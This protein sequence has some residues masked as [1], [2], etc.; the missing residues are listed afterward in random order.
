MC[1][2]PIPSRPEITYA[3]RGTPSLQ[4]KSYIN[5]VGF[6]YARAEKPLM[7]GETLH[8]PCPYRCQCGKTPHV[9]RG[10]PSDAVPAGPGSAHRA[11]ALCGHVFSIWDLFRCILFPLIYVL[12]IPKSRYLLKSEVLWCAVVLGTVTKINAFVVV[13]CLLCQVLCQVASLFAKPPSQNVLI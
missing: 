9:V 8:V 5:Y 4:P 3:V 1:Q 11:R 6:L 10:I 2:T 7:C 12:R 13:A